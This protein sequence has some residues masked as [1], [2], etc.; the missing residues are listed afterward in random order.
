LKFRGV[1][2]RILAFLEDLLSLG[3]SPLDLVN[4]VYPRTPLSSP[5]ASKFLLASKT[6]NYSTVKRLL[7]SPVASINLINV[8]DPVI[9]LIMI[10]GL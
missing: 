7:A 4:G 8:F 6:S 3:L 5:Y 9:D 2:L 10:D 1:S